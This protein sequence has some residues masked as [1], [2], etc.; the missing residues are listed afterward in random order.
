MKITIKMFSI[1]TATLSCAKI[2]FDNID[3]KMNRKSAILL[4]KNEW[5]QT[6]RA[7]L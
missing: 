4:Q 5:G 1:L 7:K 6:I 2:E 3:L